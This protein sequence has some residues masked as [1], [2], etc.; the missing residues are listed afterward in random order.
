MVETPAAVFLINDLMPHVDFVSI[1]TND[2][3]QYA[4]TVDRNNENVMNFYKPMHPLILRMLKQIIAA[5][6]SFGKPVAIC[7]EIASDPH[8]TPLLLGLGIRSLSMA[9]LL[10]PPI[11]N[12][13]LSL[14]IKECEAL[15]LKALKT[16]YEAEVV[17]YI[18]EFFKY[19]EA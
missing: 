15:A 1:G 3:V 17:Q 16:D 4:L 11:K 12:Q 18:D 10:V 13:I 5:A 14:D 7:G 2:L 8:W 19:Q 9:P 6:R